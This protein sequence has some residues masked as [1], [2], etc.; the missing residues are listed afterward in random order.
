VTE[1]GTN[2]TVRTDRIIDELRQMRT[3]AIR[4][5]SSVLE[6]LKTFQ[7]E[8]DDSFVTLPPP[9]SKTRDEDPDI[10]VGSTCTALMAVLATGTHKRIWSKVKGVKKE[11]PVD[12][13]GLFEK[14]VRAKWM[15]SGLLDNNAFTTALVVRTGG[16]IVQNLQISL[17]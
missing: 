13:G 17:N 16:F 7:Q 14:V 6:H 2:E 10:S 4:L 1:L 11:T 8:V 3:D 5:N 9:K 15:S 12:I